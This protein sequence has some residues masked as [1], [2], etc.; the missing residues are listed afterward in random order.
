MAFIYCI[1]LLSGQLFLNPQFRTVLVALLCTL[2]VLFVY[3]FMLT[4]IHV[5][6]LYDVYWVPFPEV[7]LLGIGVEHPLSCSTEVTKQSCT[8]TTNQVP[9]WHYRMNFTFYSW[10]HYAKHGD[11]WLILNNL[12]CGNVS[13]ERL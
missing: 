7:K 12:V 13:V 10:P 9:S 8:S 1:K 6:L 11:E 5:S 2:I 4:F 3:I